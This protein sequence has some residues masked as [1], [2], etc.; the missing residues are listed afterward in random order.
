MRKMMM[1]HGPPRT[2]D[3][4]YEVEVE[5][6]E[7]EEKEKILQG[8]GLEQMFSSKFACDWCK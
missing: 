1:E 6:E 7:E 8:E 2:H 5:E 4:H 3:G